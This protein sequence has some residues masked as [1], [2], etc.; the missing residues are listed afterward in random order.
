MIPQTKIR[1]EGG[2]KILHDDQ[3]NKETKRWQVDIQPRGRG[4]KR[5]RKSF[6]N[7][8]EAL[9]WER[10]VQ[11]KTQEIPDWTPLKKDP[12]VLSDLVDLWYKHHGAGLKD[13]EG[14]KRILMALCKALGDPRADQFTANQFAE[15]LMRRIEDG[16]KQ[17]T[18]N[19][20]HACLR[21]V[22]NENIRLQNWKKANPLE[23]LR[24]FKI[25]ESELAFLTLNQMRFY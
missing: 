21:A 4:G 14:R 17:N 6:D 10:H 12:R 5:V 19:R 13:G 18:M 7:K 22:F 24:S 20:E 15:Y 8:A 2:L 1:L 9:A 16:I 23:N 25:D 11:A 3:T